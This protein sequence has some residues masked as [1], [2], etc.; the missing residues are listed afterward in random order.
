M[1]VEVIFLVEMR[2]EI[3]FLITDRD[4]V[5]SEIARLRHDVDGAEADME[6]FRLANADYL[7]GGY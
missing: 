3:A 1:P 5:R 7:P 6:N 4:K 2:D